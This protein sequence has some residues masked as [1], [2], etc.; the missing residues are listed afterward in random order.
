MNQVD[1]VLVQ[2]SISN[3]FYTSC[4]SNN[5]ACCCRTTGCILF[6][7]LLSGSKKKSFATI[8]TQLLSQSTMNA[9]PQK[10]MKYVKYQYFAVFL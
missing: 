4:N 6:L 8:T 1:A 3:F 2:D 9:P 10:D 7:P 5:L